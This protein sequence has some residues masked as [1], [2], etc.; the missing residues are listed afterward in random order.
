M[1]RSSVA[2]SR[3]SVS[4]SAFSPFVHVVRDFFVA[5]GM[6]AY[7]VGGT[8]R[9]AMLGR[10]ADDVD[11]TV[12]G[13]PLKIGDE[14]ARQCGG[15]SVVMD[16]ARKIVRVVGA[17]ERES[18]YVD[19]TP[20]CGDIRDDLSRRDFTL[21][22]M[23]VSLGGSWTGEEDLEIVDPHG[24]ASDLDARLVRALSESVFKEDPVRLMR[25]PRLAAQLGCRLEEQT[26]AWM[27]RDA[28]SIN[29]VSQERVR[30][31][32]LGLLAEPN[33]VRWLREL[34]ELGLLGEVLPELVA[35]KGVTQPPEHHWDVFE[36]CLE[37]VGQIE[38]V[39]GRS[40][41]N[42]DGFYALLPRDETLDEYLAE[43]AT[44]G[45]TRLT[46]LKLTGLLHDVGKPAT[47]TVEETGRIRFLGHHEEGAKIATR[48]LSR[49]RFSGNGV[50]RVA[51]M[52]D[53]HLRP[54]QMA[55]DD[56]MPSSR[57][58][59]RYFRD[60]GDVAIDTIYLNAADYLAA[61]GPAIQPDEWSQRCR[62]VGHILAAGAKQRVEEAAPRLVDGRAIMDE[63]S[64]EPGPEIG[65]L[66]SQVREAQAVGE[67]STKEQALELVKARHLSGDNGA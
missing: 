6:V 13:D 52:V 3:G 1:N 29:S 62:I 53:G 57:A 44:D 16:R 58:I 60:M 40:S 63:L 5:R 39:V 9:D 61:R 14:L 17:A 36:H 22:A 20:L 34:D 12:A 64:L 4:P 18:P 38:K 43:E 28:P 11:V 66:L 19:L 26:V 2:E 49:L 46:L 55:P 21:D 50:N 23:A 30:D 32:L 41:E 37:T 15:S 27:R 45:H 51:R 56:R 59:F 8:V 10:P 48:A 25:G 42:D 54:G 24:G 35:S 65:L 47:R 31:E 33:S 7:L 67:I